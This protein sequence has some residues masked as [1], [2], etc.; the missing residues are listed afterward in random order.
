MSGDNIAGGKMRV[1]G[2]TSNWVTAM[3]RSSSGW[4]GW[5]YFER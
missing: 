1:H 3:Y 4:L 5:K 2:Y